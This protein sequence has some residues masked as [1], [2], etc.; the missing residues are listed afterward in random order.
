MLRIVV[1]RSLVV[2]G[3]CCVLELAAVEVA[4]EA[5][6]CCELIAKDFQSELELR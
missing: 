3:S 4:V 6:L 2:V 1:L 5:L